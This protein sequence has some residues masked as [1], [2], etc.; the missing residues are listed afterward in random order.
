MADTGWLRSLGID[1][2][3]IQAPMAGSTTVDLV[4]AVA[5]TGGLGCLPTATLGLDA[6]KAEWRAIRSRTAKPVA[7]NFFCHRSPGDDPARDAAWREVMAPYYA[8]FGIDPGSIATGALRHPFD[9]AACAFVEEARPPLVSFHFGLP[10]D[11]LLRRVRDTGASVMASA[12]SAAEARWLAPR[13]DAIIAQGVEAGGHQGFFL[14]DAPEGTPRA[15]LLPAI[16]SAVSCPVVAAGGIMDGHDVARVLAQGAAAAQLG[17]A[18]LFCPEAGTAPLHR[19]A[20]S[21]LRGEETALTNLFT[22]RP[23]RGIMNRIMRELGPLR[24]D[25][26]AFPLAGNHLAPLRSAAERAGLHDFSPLWAG[27]QF[28]RGRTMPAGDLVRTLAAEA[29][30][31][32]S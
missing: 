19:K 26:P 9:E 8:A 23:A 24:P 18:F 16:L 1:L 20:L 31:K 27:T 14:T 6:V 3:I 21:E 5:E 32:P 4:V 2:P 10:A 15:T 22:G 17:T 11:D 7:I 25:A 29:G 28:G 12:T 13:C 30:L